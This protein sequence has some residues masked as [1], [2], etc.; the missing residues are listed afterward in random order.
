MKRLLKLLICLCFFQFTRGQSVSYLSYQYIEIISYSIKITYSGNAYY[1]SEPYGSSGN[2]MGQLQARYDRNTKMISD[3]WGKVEYMELINKSNK[4]YLEEYKQ[5]LRVGMKS[6]GNVD[7]GYQPNADQY[8]EYITQIYKVPSIR[9]EIKLLQRCNS[10]FNR[11]KYAD[12]NNYPNSKRY[13]SI[14]KVL[15]ALADCSTSEISALNWEA[16]EVEDS[17]ES[18]SSSMSQS[19]SKNSAIVN[20]ATLKLRSGASTNSSILKTLSRY[21]EVE[22]IENV[23]S[24]WTKVKF[25]YYDN[26]SNTISE[27]TGY[28]YRDYIL[29]NNKTS[30]GNGSKN[31][32]KKSSG[33][34]HPFGIGN[35]QIAFYSYDERL[36][37]ITIYVDGKYIGTISSHFTSGEPE[38]DADGVIK[39]NV[40]AGT[41]YFNI[42]SEGSADDSG[43]I[44]I[45]ADECLKTKLR[46]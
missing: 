40:S 44:T 27:T 7:F 5:M 1:P 19:P 43:S 29:Q 37:K 31:S 6:S 39:S 42:V 15:N 32:S 2:I 12:P 36:G 41:H 28:V 30:Y 13:K 22:I 38:C 8:I 21:D 26:Y 25:K 23:N 14:S 35:G 24:N 46:K 9:A 45:V 33:V 16:Y 34:I 18:K 10:E 11:I 17:F 3:E 20:V 4:K